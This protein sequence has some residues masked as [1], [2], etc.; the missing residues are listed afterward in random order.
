MSGLRRRSP[1]GN[2]WRELGIFPRRRPF[3]LLE[4]NSMEAGPGESYGKRASG[5]TIFLGLAESLR[6]G[7]FHF[8]GSGPSGGQVE[9]QRAI[10]TAVLGEIEHCCA[11]DS[12]A[13]KRKARR[14]ERGQK[15]LMQTCLDRDHFRRENRS[16]SKFEKR[17]GPGSHRANRDRFCSTN[18]RGER[19]GWGLELSFMPSCMMR[20]SRSR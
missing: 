18:R 16:R 12:T 17:N 3:L 19:R 11:C 15:L 6:C 9:A 1:R 8:R 4:R 14:N 13:A 2:G 5:R 10:Q 20:G 7:P